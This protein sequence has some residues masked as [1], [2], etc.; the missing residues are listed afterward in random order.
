MTKAPVLSF[1]ERM[2]NPWRLYVNKVNKGLNST[3]DISIRNERV[4]LDISNERESDYEVSVV[5]VEI[6]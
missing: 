2:A 3:K 6:L 1:N 5:I 4:I